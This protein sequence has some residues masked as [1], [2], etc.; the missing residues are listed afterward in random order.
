MVM[1][2]LPSQSFVELLEKIR[3]VTELRQQRGQIFERLI[4]A[5]LL[6]DPIQKERFKTL[7]WQ[8]NSLKSAHNS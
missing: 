6:T 3:N 2:H 7:L 5:F 1:E 8:P 4:K